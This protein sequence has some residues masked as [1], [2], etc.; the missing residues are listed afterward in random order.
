[1]LITPNDG[2]KLV[3]AST[4]L[5][6]VVSGTVLGVGSGSTVN[7]FISLL[8]PVRHKVKEAV[9]AS[10]ASAAALRDAGIAV[11]NLNDVAHIPC[12]FDGADEIDASS[13]M[14]KGEGAALTREKIIASASGKFICLIDASIDSAI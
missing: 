5:P 11:L 9:A 10:E 4:A 13:A 12:Y 1:M 2:T 8:A 7:A 6:Y 14:I 3:V